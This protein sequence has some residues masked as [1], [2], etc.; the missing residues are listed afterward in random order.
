[1]V[2]YYSI[3]VPKLGTFNNPI[4]ITDDLPMSDSASEGWH[5]D[6]PDHLGS[7]AGT[8]RITTPDF[9]GLVDSESSL[10]QARKHVSDAYLV[11]PH[12]MMHLLSVIGSFLH[13]TVMVSSIAPYS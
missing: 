12:S 9:W 4:S 6:E 8:E 13:S 2:L 10:F 7:D 11:T 5:P 3:V 1:M